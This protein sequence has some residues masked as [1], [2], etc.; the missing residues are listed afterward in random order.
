MPTFA[1]DT[2]HGLS[3]DVYVATVAKRVFGDVS[4]AIT[5]ETLPLTANDEGNVN[6]VNVLRRGDL[7]TVTVPFAES[8][9]LA[10]LS[11]VILPFS[12]TTAGASGTEVLLPKA[13]AGDDFLAKAAE[14]RLVLRDASATW[15]FPT[16]V[17]TEI[18]ELTLSEENQTVFPA[19]FTCYRSTFSGVETPFRVISGAHITGP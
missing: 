3:C 2:V 10:T 12:S 5:Q 18:G 11:G 6:P 9:N 8:S 14:L 4:V 7:T 17:V 13:A 16:A 1:S 19:T 15:I